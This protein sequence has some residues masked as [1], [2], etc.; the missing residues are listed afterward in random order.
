MLLRKVERLNN[1]F[2]L[3]SPKQIYGSV[4]KEQKKIIKELNTDE[5]I[6]KFEDAL[7]DLKDNIVPKLLLKYDSVYL[8]T[9]KYIIKRLEENKNIH[10]KKLCFIGFYPLRLE[11]LLIG[12]K[13]KSFEIKRFYYIKLIQK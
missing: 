6:E 12:N 3:K 8:T 9:H 1:Y 11:K 13:E 5:A 2:I 7:N 10:V 4:S